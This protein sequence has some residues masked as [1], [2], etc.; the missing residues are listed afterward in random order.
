MNFSA[1]G[2]LMYLAGWGFFIDI[3]SNLGLAGEV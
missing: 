3:L 1:H 2:L